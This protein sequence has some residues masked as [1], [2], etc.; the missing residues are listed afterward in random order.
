M[1]RAG[2]LLPLPRRRFSYTA[3]GASPLSALNPGLLIFGT[4]AAFSGFA[5]ECP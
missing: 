4:G 3:A 1:N 5:T 2:L